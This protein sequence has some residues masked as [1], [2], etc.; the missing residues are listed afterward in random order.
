MLPPSTWVSEP[1]HFSCNS[2][3]CT[4]DLLVSYEIRELAPNG[5]YLP[6]VVDHN[7]SLPCTGIF[8]LHQGIQ[9]RITVTIAHES[10]SELGWKD[11]KELLV[12]PFL[13]EKIPANSLFFSEIFQL[14][15]NTKF[16]K[17]RFSRPH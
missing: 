8:I 3:H 15:F 1:V 17:N 7:E 4:Y 16:E 10:G 6:V 13:E 14:N 9:R 12:G 11:V 2:V 5:E